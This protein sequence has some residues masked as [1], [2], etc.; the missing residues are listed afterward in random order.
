MEISSV[1]QLIGPSQLSTTTNRNPIHHAYNCA[2]ITPTT[3]K[4]IK[5]KLKCKL[6]VEKI[7]L[8]H[9]R[10]VMHTSMSQTYLKRHYT[11]Q[12]NHMFP[13]RP[14]FPRCKR[15][16]SSI[17]SRVM[18]GMMSTEQNTSYRIIILI[19]EQN[20]RRSNEQRI[21]QRTARAPDRV[22]AWGERKDK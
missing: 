18:N 14:R 5:S 19:R 17:T 7:I 15:R 3:T 6:R 11:S 8:K 9:L 20:N 2:E 16:T 1:D 22:S 10:E 12:A 4:S 13:L 21:E